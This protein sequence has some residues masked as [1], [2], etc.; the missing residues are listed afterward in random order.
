MYEGEHRGPPFF[1]GRLIKRVVVVS[2]EK[3]QSFGLVGI[4]KDSQ[5]TLGRVDPV[6]IAVNDQ[7]GNMNGSNRF[8]IVPPIR[9]GVGENSIK[10]IALGAGLGSKR[11]KGA[12]HD[13]SRGLRRQVRYRFQHGPIAHGMA[14]E[15]NARAGKVMGGEVIGSDGILGFVFKSGGSRA[16][17]TSS[18]IVDYRRNTV[19]IEKALRLDPF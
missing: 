15:I 2:V 1:S 12:G 19:V 8:H 14:E 6:N 13:D 3:R 9:N 17:A 10:K 7:D 16:V 18:G 4:G 5:A 11:G